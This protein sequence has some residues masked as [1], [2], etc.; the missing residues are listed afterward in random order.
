MQIKIDRC[1]WIWIKQVVSRFSLQLKSRE[2]NLLVENYPV[3]RQRLGVS[4]W[5]G[6][7]SHVRIHMNFLAW[8][9]FSSKI[10]SR[11]Y[12]SLR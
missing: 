10:Y 3:D 5:S 11:M 12:F 6:A 1:L 7:A 2:K 8:T 4:M 9:F